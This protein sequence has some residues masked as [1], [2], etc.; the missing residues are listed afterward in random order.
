VGYDLKWKKSWP[1]LRELLVG[2]R[3]SR[4]ET[5]RKR[6]VDICPYSFV[7]RSS[8]IPKM[9]WKNYFVTLV[10]I[11]SIPT[12]IYTTVA[13]N[14]AHW[15]FLMLWECRYTSFKHLHKKSRA[16]RNCSW[17]EI[18]NRVSEYMTASLCAV[19]HSKAD[20]SWLI[21]SSS[22]SPS[23]ICC[24]TTWSTVAISYSVLQVNKCPP[25]C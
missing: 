18:V 3:K 19:I 21:I 15:Q 4:N 9:I 8:S 12:Q 22:I 7:F 23:R 6:L 16:Y 20:K 24:Q 10:L 14:C 5:Y 2:I 17:I 11:Y 13:L 25:C 1:A